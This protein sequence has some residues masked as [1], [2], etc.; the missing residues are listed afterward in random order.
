MSLTDLAIKRLPSPEKGQKV[1]WDMP[2]FGVRVTP[3]GKKTFITVTGPASA[4]KWKSLGVYPEKSL[5][6]ARQ[7]AKRILA[8]ADPHRTSLAFP[9]AREDF[10]DECAQKNRPSTVYSYRLYLDAYDFTGKVDTIT[11]K[12][13]RDHLKRYDNQLSTKSHALV[14][15]KIFFNWAIRN[16]LIDRHPLAGERHETSQARTRVLSPEE[17]K[18]LWAYEYPP[19]STILKLLILTG[20]RR[21]EIATIHSDWINGSTITFPAEVTKN[22]HEHTIPFNLMSAQHLKGEG[23]LF[24]NAKGNPFNGFSKAKARLDKHISLP[25]WTIHDLRRTFST[26][27][28]SIGTPLHVTERLLNHISGASTSGVAGIYNRHTYLEEMRDGAMNFE[29]FIAETIK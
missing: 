5:S 14:A 27:H 13:I 12:H 23:L 2:G 17:I 3:K 10:L 4:R 21:S 20:Q 25:D 6:E 15:F 1:H 9:D 24:G 8:R 26:L 29:T 19:F 11:R 7:E 22:K 28:A 16:E 18:K